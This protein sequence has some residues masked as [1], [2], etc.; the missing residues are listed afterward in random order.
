MAYIEQL[1]QDLVRLRKGI[2][3]YCD[4]AYKE[5]GMHLNC[6]VEDIGEENL[7]EI[8]AR[9]PHLFGESEAQKERG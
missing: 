8:E 4:P 9:H 6:V 7:E 2:F 3:C 5:R 1:E